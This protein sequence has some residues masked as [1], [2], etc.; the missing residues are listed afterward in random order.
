ML[1]GVAKCRGFLFFALA[2]MKK[3]PGWAGASLNL[4]LLV[5]SSLTLV[6]VLLLPSPYPI[7][8][9]IRET[10]KPTLDILREEY[11]L[12]QAWKKTVAHVRS[13]N[14]FVHARH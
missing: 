3:R 7:F 13:H 11:V 4:I 1:S 2:G 10:L 14:W 6:V 12:I 5:V 9:M 8:A